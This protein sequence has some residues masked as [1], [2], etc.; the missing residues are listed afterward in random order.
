MSTHVSTRGTQWDYPDARRRRRLLGRRLRATV[1]AAGPRRVRR[2]VAVDVATADEGEG[3]LEIDESADAVEVRR[4]RRVVSTPAEV[5]VVDVVLVV[6]E[7]HGSEE[8]G[9]LAAVVAREGRGLVVEDLFDGPHVDRRG[10]EAEGPRRLVPSAV[11]VH[12]MKQRCLVGPDVVP[13]GRSVSGPLLQGTQLRVAL[14]FR[15]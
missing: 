7:E 5:V 9:E 14:N 10:K 4:C 1:G 2:P 3:A 12:E 15:P 8:V 13:A 11:A 6:Q